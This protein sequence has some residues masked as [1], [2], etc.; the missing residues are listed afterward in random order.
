MTKI[1]AAMTNKF[2]NVKNRLLLY[3]SRSCSFWDFIPPAYIAVVT[4][5]FCRAFSVFFSIA[6]GCKMLGLL[7]SKCNSRRQGQGS[8]LPRD[9]META[10]NE[11]WFLE[12][13][14]NWMNLVNEARQKEVD[15]MG[16]LQRLDGRWPLG[17]RSLA[18]V[19]ARLF[20]LV[21]ISRPWENRGNW[22][23]LTC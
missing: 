18:A 11:N 2:S 4:S 17:N 7:N 3:M 23:C 12:I 8:T 16:D 13:A 14:L 20:V 5:K 22:W 21:P 19:F 9:S 1:A 6:A 10:S 15:G